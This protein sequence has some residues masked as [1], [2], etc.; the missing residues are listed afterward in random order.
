M[1]LNNKARSAACIRVHEE[2]ASA[3]VLGL[4]LS[5]SLACQGVLSERGA[6]DPV[7][8]LG[9]WMLAGLKQH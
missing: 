8:G 6:T 4:C 5:G 3:L 9:L 7:L 2:R 1:H